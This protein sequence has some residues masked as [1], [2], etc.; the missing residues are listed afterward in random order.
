MTEFGEIVQRRIESVAAL[1]QWAADTLSDSGCV[2]T[3]PSDHA[4]PASV[5]ARLSG[6]ASAA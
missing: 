4:G 1:K 2:L 3:I 6:L 5:S